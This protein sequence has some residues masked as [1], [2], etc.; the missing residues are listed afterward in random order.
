MLPKLENC[1]S[2]VLFNQEIAGVYF[3][4]ASLFRQPPRQSLL[5]MIVKGKFLTQAKNFHDQDIKPFDKSLEYPQWLTQEEKIA[6]EFTSLF[7]V[8]GQE[9]ITPYESYYCDTLTI[10]HSTACSAYFQSKGEAV[11]LKGFLGGASSRSVHKY[12]KEFNFEIDPSSFDM[13]DHVSVEL[14]FMGKLYESN[15]CEEARIFFR[16]HLSRWIH[17]FLNKLLIQKKS[18]F[19]RAVAESLKGFLTRKSGGKTKNIFD[20]QAALWDK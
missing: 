15:C 9:M 17:L 16:E 6:V 1:E 12:Y 13:P 2:R 20:T 4:Y 8:S 14:E 10:D 5:K 3:L 19:Y 7:V 18:D 11:G